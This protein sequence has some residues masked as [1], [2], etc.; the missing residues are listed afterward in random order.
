[1]SSTG[2]RNPLNFGVNFKHIKSLA[3]VQIISLIGG[4]LIF[5]FLANINPI[6]ISSTFSIYSQL[7]LQIDHLANSY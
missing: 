6:V 4:R 7:L 1:M 2:N 5:A 3:E